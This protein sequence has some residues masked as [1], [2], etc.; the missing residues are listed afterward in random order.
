[1]PCAQ[2]HTTN[3]RNEME[4]LMGKLEK[5]LTESLVKVLVQSR[6]TKRS[7]DTMPRG[8]AESLEV[9]HQHNREHGGGEG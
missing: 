2:H 8:P 9:S 5:D 3:V 1:M 4:A 6:V 7:K